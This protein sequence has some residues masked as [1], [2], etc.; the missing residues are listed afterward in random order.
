[1][2]D[3]NNPDD[4][5]TADGDK[6]SYIHAGCK[7]EEKGAWIAE[8]RHRGMKLT[9]WIVKTLNKEVKK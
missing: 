8:S 1:M 2:T 7:P 6:T 9:D 5:S 4:K 3:N